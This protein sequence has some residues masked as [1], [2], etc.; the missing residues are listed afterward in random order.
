MRFSKKVRKRRTIEAS[1]LFDVPWLL[2]PAALQS[3]V[4][5]HQTAVAR[6]EDDLYDDDEQEDANYPVVDGLACIKISGVLTKN[7]YWSTTCY[8]D[9]GASISH[10]L[11][12]SSVG[13]ILL[14][15]DSPGGEVSD[16]F[17]LCDAIYMARSIKPVAAVAAD[18]CFS[19]AYA[20]ASSAEKLFVTRTGGTGSVGCLV[21]HTNYAGALEKAGIGVEFVYSGS[22]KIDGNATQALSTPARAD[23]QKQ[24]D[25]IRTL[26]AETV[27][28]NRNVGTTSLM[29]TEAAVYL[30]ADGIP[31]L[32]DEVGTVA[33]AAA[34]LRSRVQSIAPR[35][36][37]VITSTKALPATQPPMTMIDD[38]DHVAGLR[39]S[40]FGAGGPGFAEVQLS[41]VESV[42]RFGRPGAILA[43]R[44]FA[45]PQSRASAPI[46]ERKISMLVCPYDGSTCNLGNGLTEKYSP[47]CFST[48]L[49]QDPRVLWG[50][51]EQRVLGRKSAGNARF[52]EASDGLHA[53]VDCVNTSYS[54][55]LLELVRTQT[56][57]QSSA[58]FWIIDQSIENRGSERIRTVKRAILR[59]ASIVSWA[60]YAHTSA[61]LQLPAPSSQAA[62]PAAAGSLAHLQARQA[63]ME[64]ASRIN[65]LRLQIAQLPSASTERNKLRIELLRLQ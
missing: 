38:H 5:S 1:R 30:G 13:G 12:N 42:D 27:A 60:A 25:R 50:H 51:D 65:D 45:Q 57:N 8:S 62:L 3:L 40:A 34:Y 26:F 47:G 33:D 10:A 32:C 21:A 58:S 19:A 28:R 22:R 29:N 63:E 35:S 20:L 16:L 43:V 48:G 39:A 7:K 53:E 64:R 17:D 14:A 4:L 11:N 9:I 41:R 55:D 2:A 49:N 24:V 59:D 6:S 46:A 54:D 23:L 31:L 44:S 36:Q 61:Q 37:R 52:W 18:S 15:F 56:V